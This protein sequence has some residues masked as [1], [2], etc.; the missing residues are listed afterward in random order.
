MQKFL[1][2]WLNFALELMKFWR[3]TG[4]SVD[5]SIKS[6]S[7]IYLF[8]ILGTVN[9]CQG[10]KYIT[11]LNQKTLLAVVTLQSDNNN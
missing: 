6:S 9:W 1:D 2:I 10:W 7:D 3:N 5:A 11:M 4:Q 8:L